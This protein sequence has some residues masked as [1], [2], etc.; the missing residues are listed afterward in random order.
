MALGLLF[1]PLYLVCG[2]ISV[3]NPFERAADR[4]AQTG[5]GWWPWA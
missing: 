1:L 3:R 5:R 4:Y 2:G